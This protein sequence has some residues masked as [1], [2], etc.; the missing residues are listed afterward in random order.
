MPWITV[1]G[2]IAASR[3]HALGQLRLT[4]SRGEPNLRASCI[5]LVRHPLTNEI[6]CCS[7]YVGFFFASCVALGLHTA[8]G[9]HTR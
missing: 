9:S 3:M 8:E 4:V 2:A 7:Y 1:G 6:D 5:G